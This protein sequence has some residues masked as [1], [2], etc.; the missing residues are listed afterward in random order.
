M[1]RKRSTAYY[2]FLNVAQN[3]PQASDKY[4]K[5]R[6]INDNVH[7]LKYNTLHNYQP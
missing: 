5:G 6:D 3:P 4:L 2:N 7:T 1:L